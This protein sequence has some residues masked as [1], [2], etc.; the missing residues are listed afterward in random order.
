MTAIGDKA[1]NRWH[2]QIAERWVVQ[3]NVCI[4]DLPGRYSLAWPRSPNHQS[5]IGWNIYKIADKAVR[6]GAVEGPDESA[7][8]EKDAAE[9]KVPATRLMAF[10]R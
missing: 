8:I 5:R 9:F 2:L 4:N 3:Y 6:L 1:A 10:R 7:A